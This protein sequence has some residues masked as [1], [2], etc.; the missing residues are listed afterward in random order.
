MASSGSSWER[1]LLWALLLAARLAWEFFRA[2]MFDRAERSEPTALETPRPQ[3]AAAPPPPPPPPPVRREIP[4]VAAPP[5]PGQFVGRNAGK[6]GTCQ[7]CECAL[8]DGLTACPDCA[9]VHHDECWTW[10][11]GC[12]TYACPRRRAA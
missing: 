1:L 2:S 9:T 11:G 3:P 5:S 6:G 4:V 12:S 8:E 7:V 10:A